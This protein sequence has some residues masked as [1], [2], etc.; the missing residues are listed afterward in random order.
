MAELLAF[1][2]PAFKGFFFS[3]G[4]GYLRW[5]FYFS[6]SISEIATIVWEV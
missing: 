3:L 4:S 5:K 6:I 1:G 2:L